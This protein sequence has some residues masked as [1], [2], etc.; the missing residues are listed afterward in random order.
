MTEMGD[1]FPGI[2]IIF[3][4]TVGGLT[5]I[6]F[7]GLLWDAWWQGLDDKGMFDNPAIVDTSWKDAPGTALRFGNMF[8][9]VGVFSVIISWAA[10]LL[11]VY[12]RQR[13]DAY[14]MQYR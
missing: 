12:R 4:G 2:L 1:V 10:G 6:F 9:T 13:Y 5:L 7:G 14:E 8:Y 3:I 11:T